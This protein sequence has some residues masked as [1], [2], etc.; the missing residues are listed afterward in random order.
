MPFRLLSPRLRFRLPAALVLLL[1][2]LG[3]VSAAETKLRAVAT[4]SI[5]ADLVAQ[6]GGDHVAVTSLVQP[7]ADAHGYAPA[8]SDAR[9]LADAKLVV[10]NGLGLEGWIDRLIKASGTKAPVV[11][12]SAGVK[13]I[14]AE[15][16]DHGHGHDQGGPGHA[17]GHHDDPHAWQSIANARIYVG[18]IRDAL[19]RIDPDHAA[20]YTDNAKAYLASLDA[21]EA[22]V[23]TGIAAIPKAQRRIITTHDA[24]GYF[25]AAYGLTF[26]APQGVSTDSEASPR[27][28]ARIIR[29]IR[30]EKIPAVFLENISDPRLMQQI[31]RE[32]G[33]VI[34][35]KVFSDALS[36]PDGPAPTYVAMM[37]HNLTAFTAA[38]GRR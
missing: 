23:R 7:N 31:A 17:H 19:V 14:E 22:E 8:P 13:P 11:V 20:A 29:Q 6:V 10:V 32:S 26:I 36:G 35:G 4:F 3:P 30:Q 21:L 37:R 38:L 25:T 1:G 9:T 12:A 33:A 28:V 2:L 15:D 5:L 34:G 24:F 27:D 16:D 18:N